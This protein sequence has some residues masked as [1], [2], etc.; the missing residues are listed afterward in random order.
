MNPKELTKRIL[1]S[2]FGIPILLISTLVGKWFFLVIINVIIV[3]ACWEFYRLSDKAK[4]KPHKLLGVLAILIISSDMYFSQGYFFG[5]ILIS[6]VIV[7]MI[8]ELFKKNEN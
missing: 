1:V 6:V 4:Y 5:W 8:N 3:G 2:V 7:S